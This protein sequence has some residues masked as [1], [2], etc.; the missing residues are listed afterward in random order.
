MREMRVNEKVTVMQSKHQNAQA[1]MN[2]LLLNQ[3]QVLVKQE[4]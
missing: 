4:R 3:S 2:Y 1:I